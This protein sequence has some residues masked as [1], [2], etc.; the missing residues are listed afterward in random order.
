MTLTHLDYETFSEVNLKKFGLWRYARHPSTRVICLCWAFGDEEPHSWWPGRDPSPVIEAFGRGENGAFNALFEYAI[1]KYVL[2]RHGV[3]VEAPLRT[4]VDSQAHARM[5]A[6]PDSLER[7]ARALKLPINKDKRG[8]QLINFFCKPQRDGRVNLPKDH[9]D[10]FKAF[11]EYCKQDVRVDRAVHAR[12]PVRSLGPTEQQVWIVDAIVNERGVYVDRKMAAGAVQLRAAA[13]A[14]AC[15]LLPKMTG[16]AV[17]S[18]GQAKRILKYAA[19]LGFPLANLQKETVADALDNEDIPAPLADLL[20]LRATA[21]LTSVAKYETMLGAADTDGRIRGVHKYHSA[22]TGRWG[23]SMVQFQ[24][25]PRP[26]THLDEIDHELIRQMDFESLS[27]LHGSVMPTLRD[28]LR[29]TIQAA[30]GRVLHVVDKASIEAR[31]LGWLAD[32]QGYQKAFREGTDLYKITGAFI[33]DTTYARVDDDQRW[34]G[35]QSVLGQGYGQWA[36][37]FQKFCKKN[38]RDLPRELCLQAVRGYRSLYPNIPKCWKDV[39][40]LSILAIRTGKPQGYRHGIVF[41][42]LGPHFTI[43]LPSGRRLWYPQA[44]VITVVG[45]NGDFKNEIRFHTEIKKSL[46]I[47]VNT[48]GG[49]LVENI[50]QAIARDLLAC[51]LL[52]CETRGYNPVMHVHDEIVCETDERN[53]GVLEGM[54]EIFRTPPPWGKGLILG[55]AGFTSRFYKKG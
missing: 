3:K 38:G 10:D 55:S 20:D 21:N 27:L 53:T 11:V 23:G 7:C 17:T 52:Q 6:Y 44:R 37:G 41:E 14:Q 22:T 47:E 35:K 5:A 19:S 16:G 34:V 33:F 31:G 29:N 32:E 15:K 26:K 50:V 36:D 45:K 9:P 30:P 2:P 28:A 54:H 12:L 49:R 39:E 42:M 25:V 13:K 1:T 8:Q 51:A 46:W 40:R 48:Y 43:R 18:P 4:W 24:N